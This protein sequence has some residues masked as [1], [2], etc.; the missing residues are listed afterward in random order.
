MHVSANSVLF[1]VDHLMQYYS[2]PVKK[3]KLRNIG[4]APKMVFPCGFFD[5]A[6]TASQGG[7]GV[8]ISISS[9]HSL[10]FKLG[11]GP[12]TNTRAELLALWS[13]LYVAHKMGLPSM[14]IYGNSSVIIN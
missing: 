1:Q 3:Y 8:Y 11:C 12:S 4:Y 7:V 10:S 13:L 5:G 9:S 6:T 2:V 14:H